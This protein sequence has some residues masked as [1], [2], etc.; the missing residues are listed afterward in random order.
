MNKFFHCETTEEIHG[1]QHSEE[2]WKGYPERDGRG[3][4]HQLAL[5]HNC[6]YDLCWIIQSEFPRLK[7][8]V[9]FPPQLKDITPKH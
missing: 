3:I 2:S 9:A 7:C 8:S 5:I 6:I 4:T 1:R